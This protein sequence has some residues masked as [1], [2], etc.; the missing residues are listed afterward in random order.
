VELV[1]VLINGLALG[2][3][4]ALFALSLTLVLGIM[5]VVNMAQGAMLTIGAY[6][7]VFVTR[8][9]ELPLWAAL[10]PAM[11]VSGLVNTIIEVAFLRPLSKRSGAVT[12]GFSQ[13]IVTLGVASLLTVALRELT[14]TEASTYPSEPLTTRSF[15]IGG[16]NVSLLQLVAVAL[17]ITIGAAL[18]WYVNTR[19]GGIRFRAAASD[20]DAARLVG[21]SVGA[22][23][24]AI[25]FVS[26]AL[27][28]LTGIV[29]GATFSTVDYTLGEH[30]FLLALVIIIIGGLGSMRGAVSTG[31]ALGVLLSLVGY[32]ADAT[33][34]NVAAFAGLFCVLIVK[35]GGV[36][37][38]PPTTAGVDRV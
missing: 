10:I 37:G 22:L 32:Y 11:V 2:A 18:A 25:F 15:Q 16:L 4:F 29:I 38:S 30:Y 31:L 9:L 13:I 34:A 26:G 5:H 33:W 27:A 8:T 7:G 17:A 6:V 36:F 23:S 21:I 1:Q 28:G 12:D 14:G 20:A 3:V 24:S 19:T 35:P